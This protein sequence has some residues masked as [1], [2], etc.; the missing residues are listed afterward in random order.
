MFRPCALIP[1]RNQENTV[2]DVVRQVLK[3]DIHCMLVDDGSSLE[4]AEALDRIAAEEP[5]RVTLLRHEAVQGWGR[6]VVTGLY[7]AAKSGFSHVLQIDA[8][9]LHSIDDVDQFIAQSSTK[10]FSLI[11]GYPVLDKS[12]SLMRRLRASL[13]RLC[14]SV[15]MLSLQV[16]NA[17]CDFRVYPVI[18]VLQ[19]IERRK[20]CASKPFDIELLVRMCWEESVVV[21]VPTRIGLPGKDQP[22]GFRSCLNGVRVLVMHARLFFGMLRRLPKLLRNK[23]HGSGSATPGIK[24]RLLSTDS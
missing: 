1:V 6:A 23:G 22:R 10:P 21:H 5:L 12:D 18:P 4:C 2:A 19:F 20:L 17:S 3:R 24:V 15:N 8:G 13:E 9:G 7:H 16:K 11:V 14:V